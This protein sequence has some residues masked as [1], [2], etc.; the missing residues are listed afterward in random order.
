MA[1][2]ATSNPSSTSSSSSTTINAS[3]NHKTSYKPFKAK[4]LVVPITII[5]SPPI[6]TQAL[7]DCGASDSYIDESFL[8]SHR[9][10][11][12]P[13]DEPVYLTL[14]DG[15]PSSAGPILSQITPDLL[16][17][18]GTVTTSPLLVTSIP[19]SLPIVLGMDWL[20]EFD[21]SINWKALTMTFPS[22]SQT[23]HFSPVPLPSGSSPK[24]KVSV[25]NP[26]AFVRMAKR[27]PDSLGFIYHQTSVL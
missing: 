9:L 18:D 2:I 14:F 12:S 15:K 27:C 24:P 20:Q 13:L 17:P 3:V 5:S 22:S 7:I 16:F 21:P 4:Q 25:V 26:F 10:Q 1:P 6:S 23:M 19:K 11:S 8:K